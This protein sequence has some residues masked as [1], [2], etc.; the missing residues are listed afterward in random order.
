MRPIGQRISAGVV[1]HRVLYFENAHGL[2][3][4]RGEVPPICQ[5]GQGLIDNVLHALAVRQILTELNALGSVDFDER[6][7]LFAVLLK[8]PWR[9]YR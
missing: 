7:A 2:V 5:S 9:G 3:N 8:K 6:L 1:V 4:I